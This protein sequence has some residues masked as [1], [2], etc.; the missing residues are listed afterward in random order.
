M[1]RI[2]IGGPPSHRSIGLQRPSSSRIFI[3]SCSQSRLDFSLRLL[4]AIQTTQPGPQTLRLSACPT[5]LSI[6]TNLQS[7]SVIT[8]LHSRHLPHL[9]RCRLRDRQ[10]R[11]RYFRH[12]HPPTGFDDEVCRTRHHGWYH[13]HCK[14]RAF[15]DHPLCGS[16][17]EL[18]ISANALRFVPRSTVS[19]SRSSSRVTF[20][21]PCPCTPDSFN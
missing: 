15:S 16:R 17:G 5:K 18:L 4:L 11:C 12:V 20:N 6:R 21:P 9:H 10:V 13:R 2:V 8:G 1:Q 19:S 3:R 14:S 7:S